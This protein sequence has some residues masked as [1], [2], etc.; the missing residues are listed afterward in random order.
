M[1][2]NVVSTSTAKRGLVDGF[3]NMDTKLIEAK[4]DEIHFV[5][6]I[7]KNLNHLK[8]LYK[9]KLP[10][11]KQLFHIENHLQSWYTRQWDVTE[12]INN[13]KGYPHYEPQ[14]QDHS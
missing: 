11:E 2:Q 6:Q 8:H 7:I 3:I 4:E 10:D 5:D 9:T 12:E 1:I 14:T 13:L